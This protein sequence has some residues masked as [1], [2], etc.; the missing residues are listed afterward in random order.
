MKCRTWGVQTVG[1]NSAINGPCQ[2]YFGP[3]R[4]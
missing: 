4:N 3:I 2:N 1:P